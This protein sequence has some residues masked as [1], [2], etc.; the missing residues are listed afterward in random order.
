MTSREQFEAR[1]PVPQGVEWSPESS[2]YALVQISNARNA[3]STIARYEAY[4]HSWGVWNA[5]RED[6]VIDLPL[7]DERDWAVTSDEFGA[8][9]EGIE[10][11][12]RRVEASGLKVSRPPRPAAPERACHGC[13]V[14]GFTANCDQC[15]PY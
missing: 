4:V 6:V 14:H 1:Y 3:G 10:I 12:A 9:R 7:I 13:G 8:M 5:S 2:R 11:M 15:I